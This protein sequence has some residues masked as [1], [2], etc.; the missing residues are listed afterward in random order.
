M[1]EPHMDHVMIRVEDK[2]ESLQ[3]YQEKFGW[4]VH[5]EFHEESFDIFFIGPEDAGEDGTFLELT[6]NHPDEDGP[7]EYEMG[8]AWGHFGIVVDDV[9]E[10]YEELMERGVEDYR[11]PDSCGGYWAFVT[12]PDGHEIQLHHGDLDLDPFG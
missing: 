5:E 12:D 3:W 4:V 9:Y 7:R 11:D 2:E 1:I 6:Y 8:N 10:A